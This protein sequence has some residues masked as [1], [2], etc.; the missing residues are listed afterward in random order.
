MA[1]KKKRKASGKSTVYSVQKILFFG[2]VAILI[3]GL[4]RVTLTQTEI[5][6]DSIFLASSGSSEDESEDS[7]DNSGSGSSGSSEDSSSDDE[8][9]EVD[10]PDEGDDPDES[11]H[12][13][14]EVESQHE[15]ED[16]SDSAGGIFSIFS[17]DHDEDEFELED[18]DDLDHHEDDEDEDEVELPESEHIRTISKDGTQIDITQGGIKT[19]FEFEDGILVIKAEYDDKTL[20]ELDEDTLFEILDRLLDDD[21]KIAT[22]GA[23]KFI[24]QGGSSAAISDYPFSVDLAS[25]TLYIEG[26]EGTRDLVIFPEQAI[27]NLITLGIVDRLVEDK[28]LD[29]I[30]DEDLTSI[31]KLI[32]IGINNNVPVYEISGISDQKLLGFISVEIEKTVQ[33]STETGAVLD[34]SSPVIDTILDLLSI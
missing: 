17:S 9:D 13:E 3:L 4:L 22:A 25:N 8:E 20:V 14:D 21:I 24:V 19:K 29:D 23:N 34:E 27:Q 26:P 2:V 30:G 10:E 11:N 1:K 33:I 18:D 12:D 32:T 28:S 5:L 16:D 15:D 6:G 7:E 31:D